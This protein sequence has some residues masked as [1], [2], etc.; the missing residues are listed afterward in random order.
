MCSVVTAR[1]GSSVCPRALA[2]TRQPELEDLDVV[3]QVGRGD[4]VAVAA[5]RHRLEQPDGRRRRDVLL[6]DRAEAAGVGHADGGEDLGGIL[7]V[8]SC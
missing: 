5:R 3:V 1:L 6:G 4:A 8:E 7:I 2:S